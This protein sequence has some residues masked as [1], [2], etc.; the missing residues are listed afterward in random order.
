MKWSVHSYIGRITTI[1]LNAATNCQIVDLISE[2]LDMENAYQQFDTG[3]MLSSQSAKRTLSKN[4]NQ[5][6]RTLQGVR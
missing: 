5:S 3:K 2:Y 1:E 4:T 6:C